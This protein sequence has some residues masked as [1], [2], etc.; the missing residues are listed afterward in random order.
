ME[1]PQTDEA[2]SGMPVWARDKTKHYENPGDSARCACLHVATL[3]LGFMGMPEQQQP[4]HRVVH[5]MVC[6]AVNKQS[7]IGAGR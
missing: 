3:A 1:E 5:Y 7:G 2:G 4:V 6:V